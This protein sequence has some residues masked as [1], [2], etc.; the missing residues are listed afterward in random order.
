M[1]IAAAVYA[2]AMAVLGGAFLARSERRAGATKHVKQVLLCR[3]ALGKLVK[4]WHSP[5]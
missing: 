4:R 3:T 5:A 1:K 2:T